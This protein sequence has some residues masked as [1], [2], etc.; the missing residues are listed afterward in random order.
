MSQGEMPDEACTPKYTKRI[1]SRDVLCQY[2]AH[3]IS[4]EQFGIKNEARKSHTG[5][6]QEAGLTPC[7][8]GLTIS[9]YYMKLLQILSA[10]GVGLCCSNQLL[11]LPLLS[12][13]VQTARR[14]NNGFTCCCS[15][16]LYIKGKPGFFV[17][18]LKIYT[19]TSFPY[20]LKHV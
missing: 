3:P 20:F 17:C 14:G 5:R 6:C 15:L 13:Q 10:G 7:D 18:H 12:A 1:I 16:H 8:T 2:C 19:K 9:S 4:S 11:S